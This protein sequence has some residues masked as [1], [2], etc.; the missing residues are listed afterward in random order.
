[1]KFFS[2]A[3]RSADVRHRESL[4]RAGNARDADQVAIRL[5]RNAQF[6]DRVVRASLDVKPRE[7]ITDI[8][9][10]LT[11]ACPEALLQQCYRLGWGEARKQPDA[12]D[13]PS[14][15]WK[16]YQRELSDKFTFTNSGGIESDIAPK[17][18]IR[19][20]LLCHGLSPMQ[21]TVLLLA[22]IGRASRISHALGLGDIRVMLADVSWMRHNRSVLGHFADEEEYVAQLRVCQDTRRRIYEA[23]GF[24]LDIFT[25]SAQGK[26]G[27]NRPRLQSE[28]T[29]YRLLASALWGDRALAPHDVPTRALIGQSFNGMNSH[30]LSML[31]SQIQAL[32]Q[33]PECA[34]SLETS[35]GYEL[36]ILRSLSELF[37]SFDEDIF[38]YYFAQFFAQNNYINFLKVA[39]ATE[40]KFD[41]YFDRNYDQFVQFAAHDVSPKAPV[42][43]RR[44]RETKL[45]LRRYV[46]F[47]QYRLGEYE[48]LPYSSLSLDVIKSSQ[49]IADIFNGLI[50]LGDCGEKERAAKLEK[51]LRVL[52]LTPLTARNRLV[53]DLL[54]FAHLLVTRVDSEAD[55]GTPLARTIA[56]LGKYINLEIYSKG[57]GMRL[58]TQQF[59]SWL[60]AS[61]DED[62]IVPFHLKPYTWDQE[63]WS[64]G[65]FDLATEFIFELLMAV[66]RICD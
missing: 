44:T 53:S 48:V 58:Y 62:S 33:F 32:L 20:V 49:P 52:S 61:D 63:R 11:V 43:G 16:I 19:E 66:R 54:S 56:A 27:I 36:R 13:G 60:K 4:A 37:S 14:E 42:R 9:M 2:E 46:Y 57:A 1:M 29:K 12:D 40:T 15:L 55:P 5:Q 24:E 31:P 59:S 18:P 51:I 38:I 6:H 64:T 45:P 34:S 23:L 7:P 47:P 65:L 26:T 25:I 3:A 10:A 35:L 28:A 39:V 41:S 30:N 50:L 22:D 8:L 17:G 21:D